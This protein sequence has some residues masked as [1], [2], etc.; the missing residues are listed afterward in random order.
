VSREASRVQRRAFLALAGA[1]AA[2]GCG[3]GSKTSTTSSIPTTAQRVSDLPGAP[4]D[5]STIAYVLR[6]EQVQSDLYRQ[7]AQIGLFKG[8]ELDRI[9]SFGAEEDEH[10]ATLTQ[11]LREVK[12][13]PAPAPKTKLPIG[14]RHSAL[15][16]ALRLE[17]LT[18]AAY[19]GQ[20]GRIHDSGVLALLLSIHS[21][22]A[23]HAATLSLMLGKP[24]TP[25]GAFARPTNMATALQVL[26]VYTA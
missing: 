9:K 10:V 22:E 18:A 23:R 4:D 13:T 19:L 16:T 8:R 6:L 12:V 2:A 15:A 21:V 14:T 1:A 5:P 17:N 24:V 25:T 11:A 20:L 3:A 26:D 7:L